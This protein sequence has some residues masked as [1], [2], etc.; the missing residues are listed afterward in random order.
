MPGVQYEEVALVVT[1]QE[2]QPEAG[3]DIFAALGVDTALVDGDYSVA[4]ES[5]LETMGVQVIY[6]EQSGTLTITNADEVLD[7]LSGAE[8]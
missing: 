6:D 3:T 1:G 5:F 8:E 4:L 7:M 2:Q